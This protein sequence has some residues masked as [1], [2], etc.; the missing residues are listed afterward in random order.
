MT[1]AKSCSVV[2]V[3]IFVEKHVVTPV[4]IFLKLLASSVDG[5]AAR[6]IAE[7]YAFQSSCNFLGHFEQRHAVTRARRAFHL[8]IITIELVEIDQSANKQDIH[9]H[10]NWTA[11]VGVSAEHSAIGLRR[12]IL[13][14]VFFASDS[15]NKW[16]IEMNARDGTN[17]IGAEELV[18]IQHVGEDLFNF[19]LV[20]YRQQ[21]TSLITDERLVS[22]SDVFY[23]FR[24]AFPE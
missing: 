17:P 12:L 22:R 20:T 18:F 21:P 5:A 7:E 23:Q 14:L 9:R 11:P 13:N 2:A 6:R 3:K 24:V 8:E 19:R 1:G 15:E 16:M 10:P 4:R